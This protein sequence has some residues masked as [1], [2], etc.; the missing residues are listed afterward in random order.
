MT[1]NITTVSVVFGNGIKRED[2]GPVKK[3][4]V[5]ITAAVD[6][7]EDG[8]VVLAVIGNLALAKVADLLGAPKPDTAVSA[9]IA[10]ANA[11]AGGPPARRTRR[12]AAQIAADEAAAAG[13]AA[14]AASEKPAEDTPT[15]TGDATT[16]DEWA[17]DPATVETTDA[18]LL[19]ATSKRAGELGAREPIVKLIASFATRT[20]GAPFKVQEIPQVQRKDYLAKLAALT[21]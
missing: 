14:P 10:E 2:F 21:A 11:A 7:T 20:D 17:S 5:S 1:A 9:S 18:E 4:E 15:P 3:A 19:A 13:A 16:S 8:A 6:E 12:T